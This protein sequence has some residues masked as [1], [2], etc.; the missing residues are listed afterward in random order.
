MKQKSLEI[1]KVGSISN[2]LLKLKRL[3]VNYELGMGRVSALLNLGRLEELVMCNPI[4]QYRGRNTAVQ[5]LY[6]CFQR[7][8]PNLRIFGSDDSGLGRSSCS[9]HPWRSGRC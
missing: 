8:L 1:I 9:L 3:R 4:A 5:D 6:R 2:N 7:N